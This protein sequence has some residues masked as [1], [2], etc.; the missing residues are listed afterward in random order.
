MAL[1]QNPYVTYEIWLAYGFG[2]YTLVGKYPFGKYTFGQY[3]FSWSMEVILHVEDNRPQRWGRLYNPKLNLFLHN[4]ELFLLDVCTPSCAQG[5]V[6]LLQ[7]KSLTPI[8]W[9]MIL[10]SL[11]R[12]KAWCRL[13]TVLDRWVSRYIVCRDIPVWLD[14]TFKIG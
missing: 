1:Q 7:I 8:Q 10:N 12:T 6:A 11:N 2:R 14:Y 5:C 9:Q 13:N 3:P 4:F